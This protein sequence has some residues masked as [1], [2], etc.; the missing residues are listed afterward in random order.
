MSET[1]QM[2]NK[3]APR[4]DVLNHLLSGYI[5]HYWRYRLGKKLPKKDRLTVLDVATGTGDVGLSLLNHRS[6]KVSHV[7]GIDLAESMLDI[8]QKKIEKRQEKRMVIRKGDAMN[9][10]FPNELY[11]VATIAFGI[12][13]VPDMQKA[14]NEMYRILKPGGRILVLEFS[15]PK[16]FLM[17]WIYLAYFRFILPIVGGWISGDRK[18]Y[19]YLNTSVEQFPKPFEFLDMIK[20]SGFTEVHVTSLTG[21]IA[22]L[23]CGDKPH[24][25]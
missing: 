15:I 16:F 6:S 7:V 14:L 3:I 22:A 20:K 12:R 24:A 4:Y 21:G 8:A 9:I 19:K 25:R 23:Y 18:A 10:P 2:F 13:N 11:D 1:W 17:R 5:D